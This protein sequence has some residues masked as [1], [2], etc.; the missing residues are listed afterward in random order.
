MSL[1]KPVKGSNK[2]LQAQARIIKSS[3][4]AHAMRMAFA[5]SLA[6]TGSGMAFAGTC[7]VS[8]ASSVECVGAFTDSITYPNVSDL[9]L[10]IGPGGVP[11]SVIPAVG[12][13]GIDVTSPGNI[14]VI[15]FADIT[16]VGA[17]GIH[18]FGADSA[19]I[20]NSGTV[21]TSVST[22]GASAL[23]ISADGDVA[24]INDGA[25]D[26]SSSGVYDVTAI[27]AES[28]GTGH[29]VSVDNQATGTV[30][31]TAADGFAI[32]IDGS[33]INGDVIINNDGAIS[34][35]STYS[36]ADGIFA[37]GVNVA[38]GNGATGSITANGFNWAVGIEAQSYDLTTVSNSGDIHAIATANDDPTQTY[39]QAFGIY[40]TGAASGVS[41]GN[42][43]N[44]TADG[45]LSTGIFAQGGGPVTV[46]NNGDITVGAN[47]ALISYEATGIAASNNYQNS[48]VAVANNG[49]IVAAGYSAATGISAVASGTESTASVINA[50]AISAVSGDPLAIHA[51]VGVLASGDGGVDIR[52][53][54]GGTVSA[55]GVYAYAVDALTF[56][57][58]A[59]VINHGDVAAV[60]WTEGYVTSA[61]GIQAYSQNGNALV[62]NTGNVS[63]SVNDFSSG[64]YYVRYAHAYGI[65]ASGVAANVVNSG[66]IKVDGGASNGISA[67]TSSGDATVLNQGSIYASGRVGYGIYAKSVDGDV[68]AANAAAGFIK[69][70]GEF[71]SAGVRGI[72]INGDVEV[73]NAGH[74]VAG[75][76]EYFIASGLNATSSYG[77]V[78]V[79]N[80]GT[81]ETDTHFNGFGIQANVRYDGE[82]IV[83]NRGTIQVIGEAASVAGINAFNK[84]S[85]SV[86]VDNS[87]T[88][89]ASTGVYM[90][91]GIF[92]ESNGDIAVNNSGSITANASYGDAFGISA[93]STVDVV[94]SNSGHI[95]ATASHRYA[96]GIYGYSWYGDVAI[97]NRG[98]VKAYSPDSEA[99]GVSGT[100]PDGNVA[101]SNAGQVDAIS[102]DDKAS[103]VIGDSVDGN[104]Q[105]ST[106]ASSAVTATAHSSDA[107]GIS[108]VSV[109]GDVGISN[110]GSVAA[111]GHT[112]T[113][114]VVHASNGGAA[115]VANG[116]TIFALTT[117]AGGAA[118]GVLA[119]ATGS[120]LVTNNGVIKASAA[121]NAVAVSMDSAVG[122]T[123]HNSGLIAAATTQAGG[124]AI[125]VLA[126][127]AGPV[128]VTNSGSIMAAA[129]DDAVAVSLDSAVGSTLKNSGTISATT[130][131]TGGTVFGVLAQ[132]TGPLLIS[133]SGTIK[134][135]ALDRAVAVSMNS[136][137]GLTL[138]NSGTIYAVTEQVD[139]AIKASALDRAVAVSMASNVG[140]TL[141]NSGTISAVTKQAGGT[142]IAVL[143]Q[144]AG[145]VQLTNSGTIKAAALDRA[146][147][148]RVDSPGGLTLKNSGTIT[149]SSKQEGNI[150]I[151]GG[152]GVDGI[153]NFGDLHGALRLGDGNDS[154]VNGVG[155]RW[156]VSNHSTDFGTGDDTIE[157]A[158]G[159]TI[160]LV[161]GAIDLG[162]GSNSFVNDGVIL[163]RGNN[164]I[165]MG[166]GTPVML[167]AAIRPMAVST[168]A[169]AP[170]TL[171]L[172]N[173]GVIDFRDGKTGGM[174]SVAGDLDGHGAI[175]L[176]LSALHHVSDSLYVKGSVVSGASQTV[177]VEVDAL[178]TE[179][180]APVSF[181]RVTGN[182]RASSFVA[183]K[184]IG[185]DPH[186]FLDLQLDV[187]SQLSANHA[188]PNLFQA[189]IRVAGLN[190]S[191]TL[192]A[193]VTPGAISLINSQIGTWRQRVGILPQPTGEAVSVAP[194]VRVF[195]DKGSV[196]PSHKSNF[197]QGGNFNFAQTNTGQELGVN[198]AIHDNFNA[199][200]LGAKS[201]GQQRLDG[202]SYGSDRI[203]ASTVGLYGSW[204]MP[205][206]F[207]LDASYRWIDFDANLR[208]AGGMQV[209]EGKAGAFNVE[210]G[211]TAWAFANGVE[212]VPQVQYTRTKVD[213]VR[214]LHG[215]LATLSS[216]GGTSERA[217]L[218]VT[219][220]KTFI[221]GQ[222]YRWTP[223]GTVSQI[224]ELHGKTLYAVNNQFFGSTSTRGSSALLELGLGVQKDR[225]SV[226]GGANWT[227]GHAQ[228]SFVGGQLVLRYT[229]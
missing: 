23:D 182:A 200:V 177:N 153:Q 2:V 196:E 54:A 166:T 49:T 132:T 12:A 1:S 42:S 31:A 170:N 55:S 139:G 66:Q 67:V 145:P 165:D 45:V 156:D 128:L 59:N 217:R 27:R 83:D 130:T 206:R 61:A 191:G 105:V 108:G 87:G 188:S 88:I 82:V 81:L 70:S 172:V 63:A 26:A 181:A 15:D 106:S 143:A 43:G 30:T 20:S 115:M 35:T 174:L 194:W 7:T 193:S 75:G 78:L 221:T 148:V 89:A 91:S 154:F 6:L 146:V 179:A 120:V 4:L 198:V 33:A 121:D 68:H 135:S 218:G 60:G 160:S 227:N 56:N 112:A 111:N 185:Y 77:N 10:V 114:I 76:D 110:G 125:G 149:T 101:V 65:L 152:A 3:P 119:Q 34:A 74:V 36:V 192:A 208:S 163:T 140:S 107:T 79:V 51:V 124:S 69:I 215:N 57:G 127:T 175:N 113:G 229:F 159:G 173:N 37:A 133:N 220:S 73:I 123:L 155:G 214:D 168:A 100:A 187:T 122:P 85:G 178:P 117:Q 201:T 158:A 207:Y 199:G 197:G 144:A 72:S 204:I 171:A 161:N 141:N 129:L 98:V 180:N 16:T 190:D 58:D 228:Q 46:S 136:D 126:K 13:F 212:V 93:R 47:P 48:T 150:A 223:Y 116:G 210:A 151:E 99:T 224:R 184:I 40:A 19:A 209:T 53:S 17:S 157:N 14:G 22:G 225:W 109:K 134:A 142:A 18:V 167:A 95:D 32:G 131:Q 39:G 90:A 189:S 186:N 195:S 84:S 104:V 162:T 62:T 64:G 97:G 28:T 21:H 50:G 169:A 102:R 9:T 92:T 103:G 29:T 211:Y 52:N 118:S 202:S 71:D 216:D 24:V 137:V 94:I 205:G 80:S 86:K 226:T 176:D 38:V 96:T 11:T 213:H 222:N 147:A 44:I 138:N 25:V 183:G 164:L 8:A 219:V 41:V 203:K 5:A